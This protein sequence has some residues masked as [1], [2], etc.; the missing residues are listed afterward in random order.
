[1]KAICIVSQ[2]KSARKQGVA[3]VYNL[4]IYAIN[5]GSY[6]PVHFREMF[7]IFFMPCKAKDQN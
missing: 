4:N 2:C 1:M 5:K 7:F 6:R 3:L